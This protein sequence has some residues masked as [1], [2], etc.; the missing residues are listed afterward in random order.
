M[1][2]LMSEVFTR[3]FKKEGMLE[4]VS[5]IQRKE[6]EEGVAQ[7]LHQKWSGVDLKDR[8]ITMVSKNSSTKANQSGS[9][10]AQFVRAKL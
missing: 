9:T 6:K 10:E 1:N 3:S 2:A 5:Y 8:E 7:L 4:Y